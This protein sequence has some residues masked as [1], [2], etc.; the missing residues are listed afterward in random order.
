[1][2]KAFKSATLCSTRMSKEERQAR[3]EQENRLR[4]NDD[5]IVPPAHLSDNQVEIFYH[6]VDT[7]KASGVL[8]NLDVYILATCSIAID[9]LNTIEQMI[10]EDTTLL[11]DKQLLSTKAKYS[12]EFFKSC[13]ELSLSPSARARLGSINAKAQ[14]DE[15]DPL[16]KILNGESI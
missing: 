5:N 15:I 12:Q 2:A 4:G 11:F 6:I 14:Q 13:T 7:M 3:L 9:R 1:M 8:S 10:N 16:L